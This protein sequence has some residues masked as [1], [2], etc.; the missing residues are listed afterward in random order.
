MNHTL[1]VAIV[2]GLCGMFGWGF[3]DFFAKKTIDVVGDL[4]TLFWA[5]VVGIVPLLGLFL[6]DPKIPHLNKYDPLFLILFGVIGALSYLP[7]YAAFGKGQLSLISPI[8]ASYSVV[9]V[10]LAAVFLHASISVNQ[11]IALLIVFLGILLLS[12]DPREVRRYLKVRSEPVKGIP[13][14]LSA[15]F[16]YSFWLLLLDKFLNGKGWVFYL[17]VVRCVAAVTLIVYSYVTNEK[18]SVERRSL[19]KFLALI[20]VFDVT[21][22]SAVSYGYSHTNHIAI[23]TVLSAT[24]SLPTMVLAYIFLKERIKP[25]QAVAALLIICGIVI[26]SLV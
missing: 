8:F 1:L 18:L 21:A 10:A 15:M 2:A 20:G 22:L 17:L 26:I 16:V 4:R 25:I 6:A 24:F 5:Q 3:A 19:W 9:V 23:V 12:S 14:V 7:L 13:E 11:E